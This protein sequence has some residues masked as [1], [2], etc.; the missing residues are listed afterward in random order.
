MYVVARG[1]QVVGL[2]VTGVGA[3]SALFQDVPE[4]EFITYL[5]VGVACF[6]IGRALQRKG[7]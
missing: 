1:L 5:L 6:L 2:L 3:V 4:A 7:S